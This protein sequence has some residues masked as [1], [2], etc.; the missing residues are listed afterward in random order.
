MGDDDALSCTIAETTRRLSELEQAAQD[1]A[2]S[3]LK[4]GIH[5]RFDDEA[6][7]ATDRDDGGLMLADSAFNAV[8]EPATGAFSNM[9]FGLVGSVAHRRRSSGVYSGWFQAAVGTFCCRIASSCA[10]PHRLKTK[11]KHPRRG[12]NGGVERMWLWGQDL[13]PVELGSI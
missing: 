5:F 3:R 1:G 10:N 6:G 4:G 7:L 9:G 8:P 12:G 2:D 11:P 13:A